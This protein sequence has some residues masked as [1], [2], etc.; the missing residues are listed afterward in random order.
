MKRWD[1][2]LLAARLAHHFVIDANQ[3]IAQ[4]G[5]LRPVALISTRRQTVLLDAPDPA[6]RVLV[7]AT[8]PVARV[9]RGSVFVAF[10]EE[11]AFV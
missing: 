9:A 7:G 4:L 5:E 10:G 6:D 1:L 3:M 11:G 8:A 2:D